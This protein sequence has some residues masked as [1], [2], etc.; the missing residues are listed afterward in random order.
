M[1]SGG[2]EQAVEA[3]M[4]LSFYTQCAVS[5]PKQRRGYFKREAAYFGV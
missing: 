2:F 4:A 5:W 1:I 3:K